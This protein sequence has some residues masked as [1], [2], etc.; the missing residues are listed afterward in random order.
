VLFRSRK[1]TG[2]I[3]NTPIIALTAYALDEDRLRVLEAGM[4]D[5]VAKP[6]SRVELARAIARQ[7]SPKQNK[8][9]QTVAAPPPMFDQDILNSIVDG[10]DDELKLRVWTELKNDL[11]R[12][13]NDMLRATRK[14][15]ATLFERATHG[16]QGLSATFGLRE[17]AKLS[18]KANTMARDQQQTDAYKMTNQIHALVRSAIS[19]ADWQFKIETSKRGKKVTHELR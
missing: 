7:V 2:E 13:L 15:D 4:N 9:R 18:A 5:F 8:K 10:L 12:H 1:L 3:K 16:L 6:I 17:L 14:R 11:S 19:A